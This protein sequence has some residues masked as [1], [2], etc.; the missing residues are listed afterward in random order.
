[1]NKVLKIGLIGFLLL[2]IVLI[3]FYEH[4]LFL[5][6]LLEFYSSESSYAQ[7]PEFD[8]MQ[9]IG[10][11]SWRY[12]LN[13]I[14]S[15]A[16]IGIAFPSR[17][18]ILF[19]MVFYALAYLILTLLFWLFVSDMERENFL[20]IFYIRRFLIQPIFVLVLL[21]AFYYQKYTVKEKD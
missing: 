2:G 20:T 1:M 21:P 18:T 11:T 8:V 7:A 19:S 6:P 17:K 5:D 3:R 15:I 9:V 12:W 10:S 4:K 16:I 13:S 14:I